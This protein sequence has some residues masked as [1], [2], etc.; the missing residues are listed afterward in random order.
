MHYSKYD[1]ICC[2]RCFYL[3]IYNEFYCIEQGNQLLMI[4][5]TMNIITILQSSNFNVL[6]TVIVIS[7][8]NSL[9]TDDFDVKNLKLTI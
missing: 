7:F 1:T 5:N 6:F 4:T 2:K 9:D 3:L 8:I